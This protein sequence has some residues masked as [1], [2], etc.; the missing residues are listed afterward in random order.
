MENNVEKSN[1]IKYIDPPS[2]WK[3]GFPKQIPDDVTDVK[4]WLVKNG[5]PESEIKALGDYFSCRYW[6]E[7]NK[8]VYESPFKK[9]DI[10]ELEFLLFCQER[11]FR[12]L[13]HN[14]KV[15]YDLSVMSDKWC[16][17]L[18]EVSINW[19]KYST[20]LHTELPDLV[21][22]TFGEM[23]VVICKSVLK[24]KLNRSNNN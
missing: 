19:K 9:M 3:Y 17:L 24:E 4:D 22:S 2:G 16:D 14:D 15:I 6:F 5:Y 21:N 13:I 11:N 23:T 20:L 8:A 18:S 12:K 10:V 1:K 7:E